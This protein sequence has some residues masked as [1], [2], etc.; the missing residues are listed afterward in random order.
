MKNAHLKLN[1]YRAANLRWLLRLAM[2]GD[3]EY[4]MGH[5][6][7]IVQAKNLQ[8]GDWTGEIL[9][10]LEQAM[11]D[12]NMAVL[13]NAPAP[14]PLEGWNSGKKS[15][16]IPYAKCKKCSFSVE[17]ENELKKLKMDGLKFVCPC[18]GELFD[19]SQERRYW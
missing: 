7:T 8:T 14:W 2:H 16:S 17:T 6:S 12:N 13:A 5:A 18:G 15:P 19:P 11:I 1:E 4:N 9:W 10:D 3:G